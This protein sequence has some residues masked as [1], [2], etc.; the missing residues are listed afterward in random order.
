MKVIHSYEIEI[1]ANA[2]YIEEGKVGGA[3][4]ASKNL[5][6]AF[7]RIRNSHVTVAARSPW[8]SWSGSKVDFLYVS[9]ILNRFAAESV[10][11]MRHNKSYDLFLNLNYFC[12]PRKSAKGEVTLTVIHDLQYLHLP[13]YFSRIKRIWLRL[14]HLS[15]L[16]S[17]TSV[18][19]ITEVVRQDLIRAY[20]K[21]WASKIVTIPNAIDWARFDDARVPEKLES[22]EGER[23]LLTVA[24]H[25]PHKNIETLLAA[26]AL[27]KASLS[28]QNLKLVLVGQL[29]RNL[30][31]AKH[32]VD[33]SSIIA[34]HPY[35]EDIVITGHIAD[36]QLGWL[37]QH[38]SLFVFP[39]LFEGFGMPPVE[40]LGLGIPVLTSSDP[41]IVETTLGFA[42]YLHDSKDA[43]EMCEAMNEML[44]DPDAFRP[45]PAKVL[46]IKDRYDPDR[47]ARS[48]IDVV[49]TRGGRSN[50]ELT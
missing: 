11:S 36:P 28:D 29:A 45:S 25:W 5:I 35:R 16:R 15:A 27:L 50:R 48:F 10:F 17:S 22:L 4:F 33:L 47:I 37:Y 43:S 23:Y 46:M 8:L 39:S 49:R 30:P 14:S 34:R 20:G 6:L 19:A 31:G 41:S 26:F 3:E 13:Q 9:S 7:S 1:L 44:A 32:A 42:R 2:I 38:C 40:A 24:A 18:V 12:P 21:R